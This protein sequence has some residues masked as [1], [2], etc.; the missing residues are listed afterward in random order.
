MSQP[1]LLH[2][3]QCWLGCSSVQQHEA[4]E[5]HSEANPPQWCPRLPKEKFAQDGL[6]EKRKTKLCGAEPP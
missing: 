2:H 6:E 3:V 5:R 4:T 1:L